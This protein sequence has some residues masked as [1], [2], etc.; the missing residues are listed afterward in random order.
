MSE[1]NYRKVL[2]DC[3]ST[4]SEYD[5]GMNK[6][7]IPDLHNEINRVYEES[8]ILGMIKEVLENDNIDSIGQY[9][10]IYSLIQGYQLELL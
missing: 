5:G 1:K 10:R 7:S 2:L 3:V 4:I 8:E 6:E 9:A